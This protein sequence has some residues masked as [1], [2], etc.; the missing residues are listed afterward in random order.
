[1]LLNSLELGSRHLLQKIIKYKYKQ[2]QFNII[3]YRFHITK[4]PTIK[5]ISNGQTG[6]K[7][8]RGQRSAQAFLD[9]VKEQIKSPVDEFDDLQDLMKLEEKHQYV[10]G[11]FDRSVMLI[12]K[13]MFFYYLQKR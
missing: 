12:Y 11:Y 10:I 7:E 3:L 4:Y 8:Y 1:M 2:L 5:Y 13:N 9:F 6:K